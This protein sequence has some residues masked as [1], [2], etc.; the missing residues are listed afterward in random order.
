VKPTVPTVSTVPEHSSERSSSVL[1]PTLRSRSERNTRNTHS[2]TRRIGTVR[3]RNFGRTR[4]IEPLSRNGRLQREREH[5]PVLTG[6]RHACGRSATSVSTPLSVGFR[7]GTT[8][9]VVRELWRASG[10]KRNSATSANRRGAV[11]DSPRAPDEVSHTYK[12]QALELSE[13]TFDAR[14][15]SH[16]VPLVSASEVLLPVR[17]LED[18]RS[19]RGEL[20]GELGIGCRKRRCVVGTPA[21]IEWP[22]DREICVADEVPAS[23]AQHPDPHEQQRIT[24]RALTEATQ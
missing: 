22:L 17:G 10:N 1:S 5:L 7:P 9:K 18:E 19:A 23:F 2:V 13:L 8:V 4:A 6:R 12:S 14:R 21:R 16:P 20:M 24:R 11:T 3:C 15:R